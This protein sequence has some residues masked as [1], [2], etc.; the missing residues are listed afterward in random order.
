[1]KNFFLCFLF[2]SSI[3][4]W[5]VI[6]AQPHPNS[7]FRVNTGNSNRQTITAHSITRQVTNN[8]SNNIFV[9]TSWSTEWS[10]FRNNKP[11]CVDLCDPTS[12]WARSTCSDACGWWVRTRTNDCWTV[13]SQNC[14][15]HSC[16]IRIDWAGNAFN[17]SQLP[18]ACVYG[19][20]N[21]GCDRWSYPHNSNK[22]S[23][24]NKLCDCKCSNRWSFYVIKNWQERYSAECKA[25][26]FLWICTSAS[27]KFNNYQ[28]PTWSN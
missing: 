3:I 1:M 21:A 5:W 9:P 10:A 22:T 7:W 14:N 16:S 26:W 2:I 6:M 15:T 4:I 8:C 24:S 18:W 13:Q 17:R 23:A 19:C 12:R 20:R 27:L 28:W 11:N 25:K